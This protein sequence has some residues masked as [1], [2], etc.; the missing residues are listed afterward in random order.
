M[1]RPLV[2]L[3]LKGDQAPT[4]VPIDIVVFDI[5][6]IPQECDIPAIGNPPSLFFLRNY[7]MK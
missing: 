3:S 2:G 1:T 4:Q 5:G 6:I 7:R